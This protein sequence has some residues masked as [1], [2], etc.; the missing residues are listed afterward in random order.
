MHF[1]YPQKKNGRLLFINSL[2]NFSAS[3]LC[4][5]IF[6]LLFLAYF[7]TSFT[8]FSYAQNVRFSSITTAEGLSQNTITALIQ[9]K[10]GFLWIGTPDGL[11][12]YDGY[13]FV[14]Y[15]HLPNDSTSLIN[16]SITAICEDNIGNIWIGTEKGFSKWIRTQNTFQQIKFEKT[17][18]IPHKIIRSLFKD[19]KIIFG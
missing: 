7:S 8:T 1:L 10:Q 14:D 11:H 2:H 16:N 13:S 17:G 6:S 19:N 9:D 15:K 18:A 4:H 3:F 12:R 5:F